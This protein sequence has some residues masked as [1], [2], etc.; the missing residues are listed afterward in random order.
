MHYAY[1]G[2]AEAFAVRDQGNFDL[3]ADGEQEVKEPAPETDEIEITPGMIEA[4][5]ECF[6]GVEPFCTRPA[7]REELI[8]G[9]R[10]A[11]SAMFLV[12]QKSRIR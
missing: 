7:D 3:F 8:E 11:Y 5:L 4:G 9:L 12:H 10:L 6:Y 2:A 1:I